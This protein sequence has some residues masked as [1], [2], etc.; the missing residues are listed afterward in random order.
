MKKLPLILTTIILLNLQPNL[1]AIS[2]HTGKKYT[3]VAVLV[4]AMIGLVAIQDNKS[5]QPTGWKKYARYTIAALIGGGLCGGATG[6]IAYQ[7]TPG[8][9]LTFAQREVDS[10]KEHKVHNLITDNTLNT[11]QRRQEATRNCYSDCTWPLPSAFEDIGSIFGTLATAK[12]YCQKA[13][14]DA[15]EDNN[16]AQVTQANNLQAEV[17][18]LEQNAQNLRHAIQND[19]Q[20]LEQTRDRNRY[21]QREREIR[22]REQEIR[23]LVHEEFERERERERAIEFQRELV[24]RSVENKSTF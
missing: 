2:M 17:Q 10:A 4:G 3:G 14:T 5:S 23:L 19:P 9:Q 22:L 21:D 13:T 20:Y 16:A 1:R 7:Y 11:D 18:I 15:Q 12:T 6:L 24:S 8:H